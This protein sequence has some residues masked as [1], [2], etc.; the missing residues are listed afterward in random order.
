MPQSLAQMY[1]HIVY[2]TKLRRPYLK[3][4]DLRTH[5]HAY[6]VGICRQLESPTKI[7]FTFSCAS[8]GS[9]PWP[10]LYGH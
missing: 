3:D 10:I 2:S 5:M 8:Q 7:M 4:E 1:L 9:L 6:L